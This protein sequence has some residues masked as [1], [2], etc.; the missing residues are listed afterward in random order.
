[1]FLTE[2]PWLTR[3][4][5]TLPACA[6]RPGAW[7]WISTRYPNHLQAAHASIS[8]DTVAAETAYGKWLHLKILQIKT[9][10]LIK[11]V[12]AALRYVFTP[13]KIHLTGQKA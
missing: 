3:D 11:F 9:S 13:I 5:Y 12:L 4:G 2:L 8:R 6:L 1:M 10:L 7:G